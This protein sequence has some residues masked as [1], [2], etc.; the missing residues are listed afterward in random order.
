M[1]RHW[2]WTYSELMAVWSTWLRLCVLPTIRR[3]MYL[4]RKYFTNMD[5]TSLTQLDPEGSYTYADYLLWKFE[6]RIEILRGKIAQMAAPNRN[7][8]NI[9]GNLFLI[10]GNALWRSQGSGISCR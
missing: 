2:G 8:Q 10:L 4:C 9:S 1:D 6:E 3:F 5:I 7:H